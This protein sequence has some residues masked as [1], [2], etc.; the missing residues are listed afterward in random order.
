MKLVHRGQEILKPEDAIKEPLV[1]EFL[2]WPETHKL[3]ESDLKEALINK[4]KKFL[5][6]LG[7]GF[8]FVARQKRLTL[9]NDYFWVDLVMYHTILKCYC[10]IDL[11]THPLTHADLGQMQLYRNYYDIECCNEGDNPTIGL[12]LCTKKNEKMVRYFLGDSRN[13]F[14]SKYQLVLPTEEELEVELKK[15]I[16]TIKHK[17]SIAKNSKVDLLRNKFQ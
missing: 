1:F 12:I 5:L 4:L 8:S 3:I 2:G 17:L 11:K 15:E 7:S 14:A 9:D 6:E 16:K 13:I 10:L